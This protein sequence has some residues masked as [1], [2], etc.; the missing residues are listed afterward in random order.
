MAAF[1]F[2]LRAEADLVEIARYTLQHWG[3]AQTTRYIGDLEACCRQLADAPELGRPCGYIRPGLRRL[4]RGRH[5]IFY[6]PEPDGILVSRIRHRSML[7]ERYPIE[8]SGEA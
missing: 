3:V 2:S 4:E 8:D 5:V 6:R 7:P 1:R